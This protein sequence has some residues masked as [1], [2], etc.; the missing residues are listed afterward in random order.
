MAQPALPFRALHADRIGRAGA[1]PEFLPESQRANRRRLRVFLGTLFAALVISIGFTWSRPAEYRA[2]TGVAITPG[3]TSAAP[4]TATAQNPEAARQPFLTEVQVITSRPVLEEA[5][6][7]L[8]QGGYDLSA[9]GPDPIASMQAHLEAVPVSG[10]N[11]VELIATGER[12]ELL[13]PLLNAVV[14]AYGDRLV[15]AH[16]SASGES[17]AQADDELAR[18][19]LRVAAKR[20]EVEAFRIRNNIVS[21]ERDEN[22]V[23]AR[24][25]NLGTSLSAAN[26]KVATAE[27][28]V[29]ALTAAGAESGAAVRARDD[30]TLAN[31]QLRASQIREDLRNLERDFT[32]EYMA[33]DPKVIADRARL[34]E[35]ERQI[36]AQRVAGHQTAVAEAQQDLV[37][38]QAAVARIQ[39]EMATSRQEASQF[40]SRFDQYKA[41]QEELDGLEKTYRESAQRRARLEATERERMPGIKLLEAAALPRAPWRPAYWR[42]TGLSLAGS[43][44]LALLVMWLVE[45][46]NRPEP[47]PAVVLIEP[48][49]GTLTFEVAPALATQGASPASLEAARPELL[50]RP[51]S[52]PRELRPDEVA[53]LLRAADGHCRMVIMLLLSGASPDEALK[54][55]AGDVDVARGAIRVGQ[56]GRE[57]PLS[58]ALQ[59]NLA[60]AAASGADLMLPNAAGAS[61]RESIDAQI[62]CAAHDAGIEA[63]M[64]VNADC[65]R[66]T[67]VVYLVRQAIRFADL[68]RLV[69]PLPVGIVGAYS[70]LSP[71]GARAELARIRLE[72]PGLQEPV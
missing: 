37:A 23:L 5:A 12:A 40:T 49:V 65:V 62:L 2:S 21:L 19:E 1:R 44:L 53:A 63:P 48:Q 16:S 70:A 43:L 55:S 42:D 11:V 66:H 54:L 68:T 58:P 31:L 69:G 17:L 8:R 26:D 51:P 25:R 28:R 71:P 50:P 9:F 18:L 61:P 39:S 27:G 52:F 56:A 35:L 46:F 6:K 32:P 10:T 4:A 15:Q 22:E 38:A 13:A 45:L 67:Y 30:P 36:S 57:I 59:R 72:Y 29:R 7:R 20:R 64:E 14:E 34:A 41:Q 24:V 47:R 33:K 60:A 3:S